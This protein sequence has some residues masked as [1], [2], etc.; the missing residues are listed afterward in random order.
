MRLNAGELTRRVAIQHQTS[1]RDALGDVV[2]TWTDR[3]N[4][5]AAARRDVRGQEYFAAGAEHARAD[6]RWLVR[7]RAGIAPGMRIVENGQAHDIVHVVE[8]GREAL[9]IMTRAV[10]D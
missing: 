2:E 8:H 6:K 4:P 3:H 1:A 10:L 7:W 5:V 9:E